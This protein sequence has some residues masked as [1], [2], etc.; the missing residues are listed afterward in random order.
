MDWM[1]LVFEILWRV[2][3]SAV[4]L[5]VCVSIATKLLKSI[6]KSLDPIVTIVKRWV[7]HEN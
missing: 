5:L 2:S 4:L 1:S 6:F 3:V 7:G